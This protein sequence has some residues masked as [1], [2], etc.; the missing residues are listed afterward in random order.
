MPAST[1][2]ARR[3]LALLLAISIGCIVLTSLTAL[4]SLLAVSAGLPDTE[5]LR[6]LDMQQTGIFYMGHIYAVDV[7]SRKVHVS[8]LMGACG[9]LRLQSAALYDG[10]RCG[11]P[12]VPIDTYINGN[13]QFSYDPT[14]LKPRD[15][16]TNMTIYVQALVEF[17]MEHILDIETVQLSSIED[18]AFNQLYF[19][20][21]NHYRAVTNFFAINAKD[22]ASL[23]ISH[24][25]FTDFINN[26]AP[27]TIEH[28]SCTVFNGAFV[29]SFTSI[30]R[31]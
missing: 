12:N 30:L 19:Y 6:R 7:T 4:I 3:R 16:V 29:D 22:N 27:Q 1:K 13:L 14:N 20:P 10:K 2:L 8:W 26:F 28:P 17:Q 11:P 31:L 24:L 15:P 5:F 23:P 9:L 21:F 25:V 18:H